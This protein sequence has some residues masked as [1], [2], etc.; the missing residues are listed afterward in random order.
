MQRY[1][2]K[3]CILALSVSNA[4]LAGLN[5]SGL[6]HITQWDWANIDCNDVQFPTDKNVRSAKNF[7]WGTASSAIQI[8]GVQTADGEIENSWTEW[9][10][11]HPELCKVGFAC[12]SWDR[13]RE[14]V[15]HLTSLGLTSYRFSIPHEKV[16]PTP[17]Y[18]NYDVLRHYKE[19]CEALIE[20]GITPVITLF[21]HSWPV[22]FDRVGAF[23]KEENI[24]YWLGFAKEV[25]KWLKP[26]GVHYWM[27]FNEPVGYCL[28]AYFRGNYPPGK[29]DLKLC[30]TVIR[31]ILWAHVQFAQHVKS[32][33]DDSVIG[34][35]HVFHP[36]HPA[37]W[38]NPAERLAAG[39]FNY[40]TNDA[41]IEF[42]KT[43][44]FV[45]G[46]KGYNLVSDYNPHAT[47]SL[48]FIGVNYYTNTIL[49]I[50]LSGVQTLMMPERLTT[51]NGTK[52]CYPEGLG[53]A[54]KKASTLNI[55]IWITECG[56]ATRDPQEWN[57]YMK[58]HIKVVDQAIK[59]GFD[60]RAFFVWSLTDSFNWR[61][62]YENPYGLISVDFNNPELPRTERKGLEDFKRLVRNGNYR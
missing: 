62:G 60:I 13:W 23:E 21:H 20:N 46:Y 15:A 29:K 18:Y 11:S 41:V 59:Q 39:M 22:W 35:P 30:G 38:W 52:A 19:L 24:K 36:L 43:G 50:G 12:G 7:I 3:I 8:E 53:D 44:H 28:E 51:S 5:L 25:V 56:A 26:V 10:K 45:W 4:A 54:I 34:I 31:N 17:G 61:K 33:D 9:E 37:R 40:L 58:Q 32:V 1:F 49:Q 6:G 47:K 48:D 27:P 16:E 14:D 57:T 2:L 42:F 55:P